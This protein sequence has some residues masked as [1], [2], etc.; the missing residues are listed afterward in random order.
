MN[1]CLWQGVADEQRV[2]NL[3]NMKQSTITRLSLII[4]LLAT[5]SI[6]SFAALNAYLKLK[7]AKDGKT[8]TAKVDA[9]GKFSF[10]N[11]EPGKYDLIIGLEGTPSE[12]D[13]TIRSIEISSFSWGEASATGS[14]TKSRSNIQNNRTATV[15]AQGPTVNGKSVATGDL[16]GDGIADTITTPVTYSPK[17]IYSGLIDVVFHELTVT[18]KMETIEGKVKTTWNLKENVK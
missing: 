3:T 9:T 7:R 16:N 14:R 8:Y 18:K 15:D 2:F 11:V 5:M 4:A 1:S 17:N 6:E 10:D 13:R 12:E